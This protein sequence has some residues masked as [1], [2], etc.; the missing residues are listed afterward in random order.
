M[1]MYG[2]E[3]QVDSHV[4]I[5]QVACVGPRLHYDDGHTGRHAHLL[6]DR[7]RQLYPDTHRALHFRL[8]T[9][10]RGDDLEWTTTGS[11]AGQR[12]S[13]RSSLYL[14]PARESVVD[15]AWRA[16]FDAD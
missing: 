10:G 13:N 12:W 2:R 9:D 16:R 15:P 14:P 6:I 8:A 11:L 1:L 5:L 3:P 4:V 7:L